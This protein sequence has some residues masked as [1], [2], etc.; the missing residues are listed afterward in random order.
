M[1]ETGLSESTVKRHLR[2]LRS[3]GLLPD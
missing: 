2:A 3:E 1:R